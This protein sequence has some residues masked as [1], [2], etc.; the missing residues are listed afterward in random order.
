MAKNSNKCI[1]IDLGT[2]YS[3]VGIGKVIL[4]KSSQMIK[5]IEL[6]LLMFH[7]AIQKD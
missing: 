2:T 6:H 5:E 3:C 1:G 4:V 7:S